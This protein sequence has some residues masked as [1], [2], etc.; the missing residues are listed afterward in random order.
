MYISKDMAN[1]FPNKL[2]NLNLLLQLLQL[3]FYIETSLTWQSIT[4]Y[5]LCLP[6]SG[7]SGKFN[8]FHF[9]RTEVIISRKEMDLSQQ[10]REKPTLTSKF[11]TLK[12]LIKM[13]G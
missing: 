11:R 10:L 13:F 8:Y 5:D 1:I 3:L 2:P 6:R 4:S 7:Q 9:T 12:F